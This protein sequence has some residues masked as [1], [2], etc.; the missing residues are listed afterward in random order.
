MLKNVFLVGF[1]VVDDR[2]DTTST[3]NR[4]YDKSNKAAYGNTTDQAV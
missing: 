4:H 3:D 2:D 1:F